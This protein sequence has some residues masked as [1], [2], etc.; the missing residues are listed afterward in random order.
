MKIER[1]LSPKGMILDICSMRSR[2]KKLLINEPEYASLLR[3]ITAED[4]YN[5]EELKI[6]SVKDLAAEAEISYS[7]AR[8]Q[9]GVI[10]DHLCSYDE[11]LDFPFNFPVSR[12]LISIN[13]IYGHR[14]ITASSLPYI[15]RRG[16]VIQ[17]PYFKELTGTDYYHVDEVYH[18]FLDG[19][20]EVCI[21]LK[22]GS[23]NSYM[24]LRRDQAKATREV[25][26]HDG[27][28]K[29]DDELKELLNLK[30]GRAW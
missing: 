20:Q 19:V 7:V 12:I 15:P 8:R 11:K 23:Y 10:Y 28:M 2:A 16:K 1:T 17:I 9:L 6:P 4:Y 3:V 27:T 22:Y 30:P 14:T 21:S 25:S 13:G 5:D 24:R 29:S 26:W 18:E